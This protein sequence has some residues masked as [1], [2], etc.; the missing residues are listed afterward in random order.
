[1]TFSL[2]FFFFELSN[3]WPNYTNEDLEIERNQKLALAGFEI[4]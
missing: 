1:M 3:G 4:Y 2:F